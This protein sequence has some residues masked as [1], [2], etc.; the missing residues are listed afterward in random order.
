MFYIR[1][2]KKLGRR[3]LV[4][5]VYTIEIRIE[6][7]NK[8]L[9]LLSLMNSQLF[10]FQTGSRTGTEISKTLTYL[11]EQFRIAVAL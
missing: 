3:N 11:T 7:V 5:G 8:S 1:K 9:A 2:A 10:N 6:I 4:F